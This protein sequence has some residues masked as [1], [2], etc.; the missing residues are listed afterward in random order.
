MASADDTLPGL[1]RVFPWVSSLREHEVRVFLAELEACTRGGNAAVLLTVIGAWK[2][3][4]EIYRD[5]ELVKAA[6][7]PLEGPRLRH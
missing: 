3:T 1:F 7:V 5:P 4:A 2:D 6:T